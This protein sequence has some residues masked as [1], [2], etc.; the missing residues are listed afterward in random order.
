M[1]E[2]QPYRD[3]AKGLWINYVILVLITDIGDF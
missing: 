2:R 1:K 3:I